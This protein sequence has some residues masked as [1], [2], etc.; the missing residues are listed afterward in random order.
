METK[1]CSRCGKKQEINKFREKRNQCKECEKEL[2]TAWRKENKEHLKEYNKK[3]FQEHKEK[4]LTDKKEYMYNYRQ[5]SK[6]KKHKKEYANKNKEKV[7]EQ[8]KKRYANDI[9]FRLKH[10]VRV[11]I[12]R[13]FKSKN[14]EK[15]KHTEELTGCSL[16]HLVKYLLKTYKNNYGIEWDGKEK[17]HIDHII[18]LAT[19]KKEDD[20]INLCHYTNL[21]LL[22][23]KDNLKKWCLNGQV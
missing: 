6:Y 2:I 10:N 17:V 9:I 7:N 16:D 15:S 22:K 12:L 4:I 21:Q 18:P 14:K 5:T 8:R 1:I 19:A 11:E 23:A 20:V 3:Y 13:S